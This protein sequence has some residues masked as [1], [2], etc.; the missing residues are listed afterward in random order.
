MQK[1]INEL[2]PRRVLELGSG[3][4]FNTIYLAKQNK[5]V[6]FIG[7]DITH[8]HV[9]FAQKNSQDLT[10]LHFE[11][12]DFHELNFGDK[13]FD[14]VFEVESVCH[15]CDMSKVLSEI[16]RV[17][18]PGRQ[19][20]A[21]DGYRTGAFDRS[22]DNIKLAAKLVEAAMAI[23]HPWVIDDWLHLAQKTGFEVLSV[24]DLSEAIMPNLLKFQ[25]LARGYFKFPSFSHVLLKI[26]SESLVKNSIAGLLMPFTMKA[27]V[28][29]YYNVVL[30]RP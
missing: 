5:D 12:G 21:F 15:A 22:S 6:E 8:K 3:R 24:E 17:L 29:G 18:K 4:G 1:H 20:I 16:Y 30:K 23:S 27:G 13:S 7:I 2:R 14:L 28:Q 25:R 10:N 9:T 11:L 26:L 19:F